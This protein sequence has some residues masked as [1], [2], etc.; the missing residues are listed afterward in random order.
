MH[1]QV[2]GEAGAA[3]YFNIVGE[4]PG[5]RDPDH[6][7][8]HADRAPGYGCRVIPAAPSSAPSPTGASSSSRRPVRCARLDVGGPVVTDTTWDA[9]TVRV[10]ADVEVREGASLAVTPGTR[11]VFA[12][13]VGLVVRDGDLQ[14]VGTPAAPV[15]FTA[16]EPAQ[17]AENLE[18]RGCWSGITIH[19]V[20]AARDSTRLSWCVLEY[21]KAVP[22]TAAAPA[23]AR[24]QP[25]GVVIPGAGGALRIVGTD[26][27]RVDHCRLRHNC[28]E[29]GGAILVHYGAAPLLV[30]NLLHDNCGLERAGA[31]FVCDSAPRLVHN[32]LAGNRAVNPSI[33]VPTGCIDH[34]HS[35]PQYV[36]NIIHGNATNHHLGTQVLEPKAFYTRFNL[37]GGFADGEGHVV[38]DPL[39]LGALPE[40]YALSDPSPCRDAGS[41][42]AA[43]GFLPASDLRGAPRCQGAAPDL[44]AFEVAQ[45]TAVVA[46]PRA[47]ALSLRA[48]PNPA[49][50]CTSLEWAGA[51]EGVVIVE[52]FDL[53]GRR[54]RRLAAGAAASGVRRILWDGRSDDGRPVATGTY[55]GQVRI[56]TRVASARITILK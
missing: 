47:P 46:A 4:D 54:V 16:A 51:E 29:R 23:P 20:P 55:L 36:G 21:A 44:G 30:G 22:R 12:G 45:P 35:R 13:Y 53:G 39:F 50:P 38:G 5:L 48:S 42:T 9:D 19:N 27:V 32:T 31:I 34:Y 56:G 18:T 33:F 7:D 40:P 17:Y 41:A 37:I 24:E 3:P 2:W 43:G 15:V 8:F 52:V 11:V 6:G 1:P 26:K 28:A 25:G 49:N 10:V 14:A